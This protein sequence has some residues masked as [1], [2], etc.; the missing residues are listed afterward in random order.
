MC[1][2][3][4]ATTHVSLPMLGMKGAA[5]TPLRSNREEAVVQQVA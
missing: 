3:G 2:G 1:Q 5:R 4:A